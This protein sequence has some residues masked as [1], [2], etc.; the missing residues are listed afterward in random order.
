MCIGRPNSA[1][2]RTERPYGRDRQQ[3]KPLRDRSAPALSHNKDF[4]LLDQDT[5]VRWLMDDWAVNVSAIALPKSE[6]SFNRVGFA[7]LPDPAR[8]L[9]TAI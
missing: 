1:K 9:Q 4:G 3:A 5:K 6:P 8:Q 2:S 7:E